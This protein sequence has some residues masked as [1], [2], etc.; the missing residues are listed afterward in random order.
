MWCIQISQCDKQLS[1]WSGSPAIALVDAHRVSI[2]EMLTFSSSPKVTPL[3]RNQNSKQTS[4]RFLQNCEWNPA[5][6]CKLSGTFPQSGVLFLVLPTCRVVP[7]HWLLHR[8][9]KHHLGMMNSHPT[10][11]RKAA[12]SK[13]SANPWEI[14][15]SSG[16]PPLEKTPLSPG[17]EV[18]WWLRYQMTEKPA[19]RMLYLW[20]FLVSPT[21]SSTIKWACNHHLISSN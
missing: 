1:P 2:S 14:H 16:H 6:C 19:W 13:C 11:S 5:I 8:Y 18:R 12:N 21:Q 3:T 15:C 17:S 9:A 20:T 10:R 7:N 4:S